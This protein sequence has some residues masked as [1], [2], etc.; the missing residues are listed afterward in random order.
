MEITG[1]VFYF[2]E[3]ALILELECGNFEVINIQNF[4]SFAVEVMEGGKDQA[5]LINILNK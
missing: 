5:E 2:C 3:T 4:D 1:T